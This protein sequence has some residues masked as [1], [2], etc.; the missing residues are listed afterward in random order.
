MYSIPH[1]FCTFKRIIFSSYYIARD[2]GYR[3]DSEDGSTSFSIKASV[4][5]FRDILLRIHQFAAHKTHKDASGRR[6]ASSEA[7]DGVGARTSATKSM[8]VRSVSCS[9]ADMIGI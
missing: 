3:I 9:T 2:N 4:D 1:G 8:I 6:S 7:I 5:P